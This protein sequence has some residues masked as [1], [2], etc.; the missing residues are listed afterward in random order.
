M[1]RVYDNVDGALQRLQHFRDASG[2]TVYTRSSDT[3]SFYNDDQL[4]CEITY[5]YDINGQL[6]AKNRQFHQSGQHQRST[7]SEFSYDKLGRLIDEVYETNKP[8]GQ[9]ACQYTYDNAGNRQTKTSES[10]QANYTYNALHQLTSDCTYNLTYD[11]LGYQTRAELI[12]NPS[13][14]TEY[15]WD[16]LGQLKKVKVNGSTVAEYTYDGSGSGMLQSRTAGGQTTWYFWDGFSPTLETQGSDAETSNAIH[17]Y[18]NHPWDVGGTICRYDLGPDHQLTAGDP[19]IY[20]LHDEAGN[21]IALADESGNIIHTFEQDAWGNDL[22]N[23]FNNTQGVSHHQ[24]GKLW[25][26]AANLYYNAARWYDPKTGRFISVS[27]LSPFA[28]EEYAFC[29]N[30]P[31][32][33]IDLNGLLRERIKGW[34]ADGFNWIFQK[35]FKPVLNN[36]IPH[37][38][39]NTPPGL[40]TQEEICDNVDK[41]ISSLAH[42]SADV[43]ISEFEERFFL[44]GLFAGAIYNGIQSNNDYDPGLGGNPFKGKTASEIDSILR[45][46]GFILK[47]FDPINGKGSYINPETGRMFWIDPGKQYKKGFE[48]PHVDV[49]RPKYYR[50]K[51]LK[52]KLWR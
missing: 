25:D 22:G 46:K 30:D 34:A 40:F 39:A 10:S 29:G 11:V 38:R 4:I 27:P 49:H 32:N 50:G 44:I 51:L 35:T 7:F 26:E 43:I 47:K 20:Y 13:E 15:E 37:R 2:D 19:A 48:S 18:F 3:F 41:D 17:A 36:I 12:A 1:R 9:F 5:A 6:I 21:V 8:G 42:V 45:K 33:Y 52:K 24:T 14:Y 16:I 31:V 23:T 28:E